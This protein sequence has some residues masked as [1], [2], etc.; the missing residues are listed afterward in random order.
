[1]LHEKKYFFC[2]PFLYL[3]IGC[4]K[5]EVK[6]LKKKM[7]FLLVCGFIILLVAC[8]T[9]SEESYYPNENIDITMTGENLKETK[10]QVDTLEKAI[11]HHQPFTLDFD[12]MV[13][14]YNS[15]TTITSKDNQFEYF[16]LGVFKQQ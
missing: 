5:L 6:P 1:L 2:S 8:S 13:N 14:L 16:H 15:T 10:K 3:L 11:K 7:L 4:E 12:P 9:E